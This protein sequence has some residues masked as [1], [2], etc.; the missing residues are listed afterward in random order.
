MNTITTNAPSNIDR[1]GQLL[2][3]I[4]DLT[5]E[6]DAIKDGLKD[7][8]SLSGQKSFEGDLFKAAYIETN[9]STVDWKAVAKAMNIPA[10]LIAEHTKTA[11]V[12]SIKVTSK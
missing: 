12:F 2:A 1:L 6:A 5:K 7:E 4:A 10:E 8:A 9:R 11:A 3:Q